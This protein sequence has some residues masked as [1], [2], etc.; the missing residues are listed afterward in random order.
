MS[1]H[2]E[3]PNRGQSSLG[4]PENVAG[5][6]TYTFGFVTGIL[7]IVLE[8]ESRLVKFHAV[9]SILFSLAYLVVALALRLIPVLGW[10][11]YLL[12]PPLGLIVWI[13]LMLKAY[14]FEC[15]ELPL[16]GEIARTQL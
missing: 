11:I 2:D 12:L 16:I 3:M 10:I 6:L 1:N 8:R 4:M 5:L 15:F 7:F 13:V 14:R 9:Q